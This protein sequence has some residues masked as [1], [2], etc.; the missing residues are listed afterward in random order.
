M[1]RALGL[2]AR[3]PRRVGVVVYGVR[4]P[5][6]LSSYLLIKPHDRRR[7]DWPVS[8][9]GGRR[10]P[11]ETPG[12]AAERETHEETGVQAYVHSVVH[13]GEL[14]DYHLALVAGAPAPEPCPR[15]PE[16]DWARWVDLPTALHL[17]RYNGGR[18]GEEHYHAVLA[19]D[20]RVHAL[21][22]RYT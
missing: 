11:E 18:W 7:H 15:D 1:S 22:S 19:A 21:I 6:A 17:L 13:R 3:A 8:I 9:P 20:A 12:A 2:A 14:T 4:G 10:E 5:D 16:V